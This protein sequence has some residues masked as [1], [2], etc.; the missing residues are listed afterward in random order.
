MASIR[1][2]LAVFMSHPQIGK[3][4]EMW[5]LVLRIHYKQGGINKVFGTNHDT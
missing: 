2:E 1:N 5:L 3:P 4:V